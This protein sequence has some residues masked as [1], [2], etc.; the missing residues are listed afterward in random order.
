M[1]LILATVTE[2]TVDHCRVCV[3]GEAEVRTTGYTEPFRPRAASLG[4]GCLVAIDVSAEPP[5]VA[6]R[7]FPATVLGVDP[8]TLDEPFHGVIEATPMDPPPEIGDTVYV[9][10]GPAGE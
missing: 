1:Q 10:T 9:A 3:L 5:L 6:W 7:W 8:L 2:R 4:P